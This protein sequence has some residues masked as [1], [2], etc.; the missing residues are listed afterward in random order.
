MTIHKI[1]IPANVGDVIEITLVD[2]S[3]PQPPPP[4]P[5]ATGDNLLD[6]GR[7]QD[8]ALNPSFEGWFNEDGAHREFEL[9]LH[10]QL[11]DRFGAG[12]S[13]SATCYLQ[14]D[15]DHGG[16]RNDQWAYGVPAT[17]FT[18]SREVAPATYTRLFYGWEEAH[19]IGE[20]RAVVEVYGLVD[21]NWEHLYTKEGMRSPTGTGKPEAVG[22]AGP[23]AVFSDEITLPH[24]YF[25]QFKLRV[26][27]ELVRGPEFNDGWLL[28]DHKLSVL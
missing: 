16:A 6:F 1:D 17:C 23:P 25:V 20:A 27:G 9:S 8:A 3:D 13:P 14:C 28:G 21:G 26:T 2:P 22:G 4:P 18:L 12:W 5:P 11:N 7:L 10:R 19:H 24:N 15:N